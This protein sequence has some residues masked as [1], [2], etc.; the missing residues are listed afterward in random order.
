MDDLAVAPQVEGGRGHRACRNRA[1][2]SWIYGETVE[3][4]IEPEVVPKQGGGRGESNPLSSWGHSLGRGPPR[5]SHCL[6]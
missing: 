4:T 5:V 6:G 2:F 1:R 3:V